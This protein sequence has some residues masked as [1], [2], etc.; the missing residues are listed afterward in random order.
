MTGS[1]QSRQRS[2]QRRGFILVLVLVVVALITLSTYT[3]SSL[4]VTENESAVMAGH[5]LQ[6]RMSVD[7]G[8]ANTRYILELLPSERE[9]LGG[10][11]SNP[12]LF[13]A[14]LVVDH[15]A[16]RSRARFGIVSPAIDDTGLL[17]GLRFGL[18][19]ESERLNINLLSV[20][21][22][23]SQ[24]TDAAAAATTDPAAGGTSTGGTSTGGTTN[25]GAAPAGTGTTPNQNPSNTGSTG[26]TSGSST[27]T[28]GSTDDADISSLANGI[29][30]ATGE[31][32]LMD[33]P[34]MTIEVAHA[35]LDWLDADDTPREYGAEIDYYSSLSPPYSPAN[36]PIKTIEELLLVRGVTPDLLFGRDVN[37][38]GM[39]DVQEQ[40]LPLNVNFE[41]STGSMDLGW[42]AYLTLYSQEKNVASDGSPRIN[43][44]GDDLQTLYDDLTEVV[45]ESWATYIVA[46]RQSGPYNANNNNADPNA[47]PQ[48]EEAAGG[49]T[50]DLTQSPQ[51]Q[52]AQLFDL[53][54]SKVQAKL[55]NNEGTVILTSPFT[56]SP[57]EMLVYLP[58]LMDLCTSNPAQTIPGRVNI[59][60]ASRAVLLAVPG[61][62]EDLVDAII[63]ARNMANSEFQEDLQTE[64][65][66]LT[67]ALVSLDDMKL[68][69]PYICAGGDV[70]RAQVIGYFDEGEI[71]SR[72]EVIFDATTAM[73]RILSW[74][75]MGHLGRGYARETLG[76]DLTGATGY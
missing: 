75:D 17:G 3:F 70:Y 66:L 20:L 45:D 32:I 48:N 26:T 29:T 67:H 24:V 21:D 63:S 51:G 7:S 27:G 8:V 71:A 22:D 36:G 73:P 16:A 74:K 40:S 35:I 60:R 33:L 19:D 12:Q 53:I 34:G 5:Q 52:I 55:A 76:V 18:Q 42:A 47:T 50:L 14:Q 44:N 64:A 10:L 23:A 2:C 57:A 38:N 4:M 9:G 69:I 30:D 65:W 37:R 39:L 68:L 25:T 28:T 58:K 49:Q 15:D 62:N 46:Y 43:V 72:A 41:D 56:D 61:M 6:A 59:N 54:G 31:A 11:Y 13:Q 1:C